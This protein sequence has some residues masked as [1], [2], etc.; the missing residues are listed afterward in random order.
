MK[1]WQVLQ[2]VLWAVTVFLALAGGQRIRVG[3]WWEEAE[4]KQVV[5]RAGRPSHQN[6]RR[7]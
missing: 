2:R 3:E 1:G 7:T 4:A 6:D 5:T